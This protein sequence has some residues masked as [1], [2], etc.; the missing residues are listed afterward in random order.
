MHD[1]KDFHLSIDDDKI[2]EREADELTCSLLI[3]HNENLRFKR[4]ANFSIDKII[5]LSQ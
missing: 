3:S 2:L 5:K 4:N 1:R